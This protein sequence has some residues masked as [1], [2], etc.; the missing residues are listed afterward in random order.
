MVKSGTYNDF[1]NDGF[2]NVGDKIYYIFAVTNVGNVT[3]TG[4]TI[5]D[6]D[7][8]ITGGPI[9]S[10]AP[11]AVDTTTFTGEY[12]LTQLDINAGTFTNTATVTGTP[13][14]GPNVTII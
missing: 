10:L 8:T 5:S 7:A 14:S 6:P 13:P 9:V 2:V 12:T 4:I 3:L 11:G 1:N